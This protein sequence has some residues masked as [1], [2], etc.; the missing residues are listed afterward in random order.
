MN[1]LINYHMELWLNWLI[2]FGIWFGI[3]LIFAIITFLIVG[4]G[5]APT[6]DIT[7]ETFNY[8]RKSDILPED[9]FFLDTH[10]HTLASDGVLSPEQLILWHIANGYD[11]FVLTDHNTDKN[12]KPIVEL[13]DKYPE[14]VIIP[15]FE[16]TTLR[17][18]LN[19]LGIME[20]SDKVPINPSDDQIREAI[21]K[22]KELGAIVQV[23]H[24]S[25]TVDQPYH[26]SGRTT[27]PTREQLVEWGADGFEINNEMRWYDPK[28]LHWL[29]NKRENGE[30]DRPIYRSTG[31][32]VHNP[33]KEWA[34]GWTEILL[35]DE[36]RKN[37]N[38]TTIKKA[39]LEARTKIWVDHDYVEP[40]ELKKIGKSSLT[41]REKLFPPLFA[42]KY[43]IE[44]I[45]GTI[46]GII[47]YVVW[48][49]VA[50]FP[51]RLIFEVMIGS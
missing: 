44:H 32:D 4:V 23:D 6:K 7:N 10:A 5:I 47:M 16:W 48:V 35:T 37:P 17:I 14:I 46:P 9:G 18:H 30:L 19:F 26:R 40:P 34:T 12:N 43:G 1:S 8:S 45:P 3:I 13:Q 49:L 24:I 27:H 11:A 38:W 39:L 20:W 25:W 15:G 41:L 28:T 51:L 29:D 22:A 31:T 21:R 33:L 42:L 36:E 50:Y 2:G